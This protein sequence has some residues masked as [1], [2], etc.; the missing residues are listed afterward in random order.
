M[1]AIEEKAKNENTRQHINNLSIGETFR[2]LVKLYQ[3]DFFKGR[4]MLNMS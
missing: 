2:L 1:S 4:Q 3:Q